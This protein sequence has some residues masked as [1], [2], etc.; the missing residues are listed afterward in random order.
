MWMSLMTSGVKTLECPRIV[1]AEGLVSSAMWRL[2]EDELALA[3][4]EGV[5]VVEDL[6]ADELL[7]LGRRAEPVDAELPLDELGVRVGPLAGHAV[8]A[9]RLHLAADVDLAV[10]H[11][12]AQPGADVPDDDLAAALHHEARHRA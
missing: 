7:Q 12:V 5:V 4:L 6:A 2:L 9:E 11:G 1:F 3:R 8:D 10:V